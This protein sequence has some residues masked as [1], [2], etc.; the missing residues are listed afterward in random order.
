MKLIKGSAM[1]YFFL[2]LLIGLTQIE[3]GHG[4]EPA[5]LEI[6][7]GP[8]I[9]ATV[10]GAVISADYLDREMIGY[11]QRL[12]AQGQ[13]MAPGNDAVL[14]EKVLDELISRELVYQESQKKGIQVPVEDIDKII[15]EIKQRYPDEK[16]FQSVLQKMNVTEAGLREQLTHQSAIRMFVDQEIIPKISV[17]EEQSKKFYD[18]NPQYYRQPDMV[19]AVTS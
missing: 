7:A 4:E 16:T 5:S 15:I 6:T 17:S 18:E 10:N 13:S 11:Q 3:Y 8:A 9:V 1:K 14:R 12:K 19:H 2:I